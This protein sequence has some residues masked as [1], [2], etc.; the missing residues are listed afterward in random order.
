MGKLGKIAL[1][2]VCLAVL[3]GAVVLQFRDPTDQGRPYIAMVAIVIIGLFLYFTRQNRTGK[4]D[5]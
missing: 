1:G 2:M 5:S 4:S 3:A